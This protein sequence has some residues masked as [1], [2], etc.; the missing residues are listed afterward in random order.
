MFIISTLIKDFVYADDGSD[1][2][3]AVCTSWYMDYLGVKRE[4]ESLNM[5]DPYSPQH[6]IFVDGPYT[7]FRLKGRPTPQLSDDGSREF[8]QKQSKVTLIN[9]PGSETDKRT[10]YLRKA[11][12]LGCDVIIIIDSDEYLHPDWRDWKDFRKWLVKYARSYDPECYGAIFNLFSWIDKDYQ[13]AYNTTEVDQF[14]LVPRVW[15]SPK[16][17]E[18]YNGVHY[19]VRRKNSDVAGEKLLSTTLTIQH[20]IRLAQDS[21]LRDPVML[22]ARDIC[23]K[24]NIKHEDSLIQRYNSAHNIP[25]HS[26]YEN[27][28]GKEKR[29]IPKAINPLL[30]VT[31]NHYIPSVM[32]NIKKIVN[33]DKIYL[34]GFEHREEVLQKARQFFLEHEEYSHLILTSDAFD[35]QR[36]DINNLIARMS[37]FD[38]IGGCSSQYN[39]SELKTLLSFSIKDLQD[40]NSKPDYAVELMWHTFPINHF[41]LIEVKY[42]DLILTGIS[43]SLIKSHEFDRTKDIGFCWDVTHAG[44]QIFIDPDLIVSVASSDIPK[45]SK[46]PTL[47]FEKRQVGIDDFMV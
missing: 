29:I 5:E 39:K 43:R 33:V 34:D 32:N 9:Y 44:Y 22:E 47:L 26:I 40:W 1:I 18:Y 7:F 45:I 28:F 37:D 12:E 3:I 35:I 24:N 42:T 13:K 25:Y 19:W 41:G 6:A 31:V 14:T 38:I 30:A 36:S 8:L 17:F 16:N 2:V 21:K 46:N 11:E 4:Y 10:A 20:G 27:V 15:H 23:N